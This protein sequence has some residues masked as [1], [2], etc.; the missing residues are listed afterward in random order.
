MV[1]VHPT[2]QIPLNALLL[3][4]VIDALLA[5]IN[6]GSSTAFNALV[7]LPTIALYISYFIPI[8]LILIR[9][10]RG[11]HPA[12]GPWRMGRWGVPINIFSLVYI[13]YIVIWTPWPQLL[14]VTASTF[15]YSGPILLAVILF[16]LL[17]WSISGRKRFTVPE[18]A[19]EF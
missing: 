1:Q 11:A 13:L 8:T 16:A 14:P 5:L 6:I 10:L 9:K 4:G 2:L 3:V 17:D 19:K 15:N 12:Y 18:A 7:S